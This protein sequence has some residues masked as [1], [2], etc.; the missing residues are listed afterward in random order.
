MGSPK[1]VHVPLQVFLY[2]SFRYSTLGG[3]EISWEAFAEVS[4]GLGAVPLFLLGEAVTGNE[5]ENEK[6]GNGA[7]GSALNGSLCISAPSRNS[8]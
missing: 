3:K 6:R 5:K 4:L 8:L 7:L 1:S 2:H